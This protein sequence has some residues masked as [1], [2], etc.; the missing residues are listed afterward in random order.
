MEP[1]VSS[2]T[3]AIRT[4]TPGNYP[5][6]NKLHLEH[7]E[8]LKTRILKVRLFS[9]ISNY[10]RMELLQ[11]ITNILFSIKK[12]AKFAQ[13]LGILNNTLKPSLVQNH[14]FKDVPANTAS[15]PRMMYLL[16]Y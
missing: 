12:L 14:L 11:L 3:L 13:I 4:Q 6:R 10:C 7:S 8:S 1:I 16:I 9:G 5:K 2:E 15:L